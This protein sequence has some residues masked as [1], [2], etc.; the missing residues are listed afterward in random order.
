MSLNFGS[1][2][3]PPYVGT[4]VSIGSIPKISKPFGIFFR[5]C[6]HHDAFIG[7]SISANHQPH[8]IIGYIHEPF[9]RC[10]ERTP[11]FRGKNNCTFDWPS[12]GFFETLDL[13][14]VNDAHTEHALRAV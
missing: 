8:K 2:C 11:I 1:I 13:V 7:G 3:Y 12:E 10:S 4:V 9:L 5:V 14:C 6:G